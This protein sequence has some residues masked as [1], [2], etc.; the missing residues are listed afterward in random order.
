MEKVDDES[1][2]YAVEEETTWKM[3]KNVGEMK[4]E[5]ADFE[6]QNTNTEA[7]EEETNNPS[8]GKDMQRSIRNDGYDGGNGDAFGARGSLW[9]C[10]AAR[11][12]KM[13]VLP[14]WGLERPREGSKCQLRVWFMEV[15]ENVCPVPG[16][17]YQLGGWR[18]ATIGEADSDVAVVLES[19]VE[20][21]RKGERCVIG[22]M[23]NPGGWQGQQVNIQVGDELECEKSRGSS[24]GEAAQV[25]IEEKETKQRTHDDYEEVVQQIIGEEEGKVIQSKIPKAELFF[26]LELRTFL[27]AVEPWVASMKECLERA[28]KHRS[29]GVRLFGAGAPRDAARRFGRAVRL[30]VCIRV[31]ETKK[32]QQKAKSSEHETEEESAVDKSEGTK[33]EYGKVDILSEDLESN[34]KGMGIDIERK[35]IGT[36]SEALAE[37]QQEASKEMERKVDRKENSADG[38]EQ[39]D[40][41]KGESEVQAL[42]ELKI[43][44][45]EESEQDQLKDEVDEE[46]ASLYANLAACHLS[47]GCFR[48]AER[49]CDLALS[50]R[51]QLLKALYRRGRAR[52]ERGDLLA[53]REDLE[54]LLVLEPCCSATKRMLALVQEREKAEA[55]KLGQALCKM[56]S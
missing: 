36:K 1:D 2:E 38:K 41:N 50:L 35:R 51:P 32:K 15:D 40:Q 3:W 9:H 14:G 39:E 4:Q 7:L 29:H 33:R 37:L 49:S 22:L 28:R 23:K 48:L 19:C 30:L 5:R 13:I 27:P 17:P 12:T 31:K 24:G 43:R 56:F 8:H 55:R 54:R 52:L 20:S 6:P 18:W 53:A 34:E 44:S 47:L 25:V 10:P 46:L 21:M 45:A 42:K 26:I 16:P 11:F